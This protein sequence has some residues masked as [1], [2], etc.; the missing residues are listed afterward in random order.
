MNKIDLNADIAEGGNHDTKI[1]QLVSSVNIACGA[2]AGDEETM[3]RTITECMGAGVAIGAHPGYDDRSHFGRRPLEISPDRL[4]ES[5]SAQL[6]LFVKICDEMGATP[7]HV[8]PH[9]ALYH[10]ANGDLILASHLTHTVAEI[11]PGTLLYCPPF[12]ALAAAAQRS[13]LRATAEGFA[14]RRYLD[15]GSLVPRGESTAVISNIED[16]TQQAIQIATKQEVMTTTHRSIP[17]PA[18]TI[19]THGDGPDPCKLLTSIRAKFTN[20][21]ICLQAP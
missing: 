8:K 7:H 16:A 14:D 15:D 12:G 20:Q 3:R 5:I 10:Q 11:L 1:I 6:T 4:R 9:G 2:H 21:N 19:C 17:L 18:L 13:G